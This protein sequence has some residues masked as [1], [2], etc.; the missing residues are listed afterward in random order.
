MTINQDWGVV[1]EKRAIET[2][3]AAHGKKKKQRDTKTITVKLMWLRIKFRI[4]INL[5]RYFFFTLVSIPS[6]MRGLVDGFPSK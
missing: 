2:K 5:Q 1:M 6:R 4:K 3:I